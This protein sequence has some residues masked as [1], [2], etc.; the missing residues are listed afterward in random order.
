MVLL[1]SV[2]IITVVAVRL[3]RSIAM[4]RVLLD[5]PNERSSH[6]V[7]VP[8][9]GGAAF[10]PVVMVAVGLGWF[11]TGLPGLVSLAF[12]AGCAGLFGIGLLDDFLSLPTTVRFAVQF[13]VAFGVLGAIV[14]S[15][16]ELPVSGLV[17]LS[18]APLLL[19]AVLLALWIVG[20]LNIYNF[21]DG[22]DGIAGLQAVVGG[23]AWWTIALELDARSAALLGSVLAAGALGFLTLNWP[24]AKIFMGDAGSTVIG[25]SFGI[26]PLLVWVETRGTADFGRLL[27]AAGLVVWPFLADG[28]FT[29]FRRLK[30]RENIFKAHRSHLYQRLVMCG[31]AH[32]LITC[33]YGLLAVIGGLLAWRVIVSASYAITTAVAVPA[34]CFLLLWYWVVRCERHRA[35][36]TRRPEISPKT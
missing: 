11:D 2:V 13:A 31:K 20:L 30:N 25:F 12:F 32:V 26:L 10:I 34:L 36:A 7:P 14:A 29:I 1:A 5:V 6:Q 22:I 15:D 9:L 17:T 35:V 21:L 8:R 19:F 4:K 16:F 33:A 24:P 28:T 18:L 23:V 27:V 3:A